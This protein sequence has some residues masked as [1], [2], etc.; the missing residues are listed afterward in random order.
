MF[1]TLAALALILLAPAAHA[2][3]GG[4]R[5]LDTRDALRGWEAVGRVDMAPAPGMQ[6]AFC[7]G[8][9]IAPDLVLTAAHCLFDA[10]RPRDPA[11]ITFRAALTN[12]TALAQARVVAAAALPGYVPNERPD[13]NSIRHDIA[14]MRL[15]QPISTA[16]ASPFRIDTPAPGDEVS[17]LSYARGRSEVMSRERVCRVQGRE[18]G[19][20]AFDC[21]V[22][23]GSSGAPV[24][25]RTPEAGSGRMRIV[26]IISAGAE[27]GGPD[28]LAWGPDLPAAVAILKPMLAANRTLRPGVAAAPATPASVPQARRLGAGDASRDTGARF[29]KPRVPAAP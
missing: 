18:P 1:R 3:S 16:I 6:G 28:R 12:G 27:A 21:D 8:A 24:F 25:Q 20:M 9:L 11:S 14:L 13:T 29:L 5:A 15:D 23:F 4:A 7:T 19:L 22:T 10:G 2:Q 17:V 26:S